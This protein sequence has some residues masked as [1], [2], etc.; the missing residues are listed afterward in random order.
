MKKNNPMKRPEQRE[1]MKNGAAARANSFNRSPS[2]EQIK[3]YKQV[4]KFYPFAILNY[5]YKNYSI[6]IAIQKLKIAIEFDGYY[7]HKG[8][9][10]IDR[11]RQEELEKDGWKFIRYRKLPNDN[12][13][14]KDL[15]GLDYEI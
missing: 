4:L 3:L 7:W 12:Q 15:L 10:E 6:D 11:K 9:E 14:N 8:R 2:K 5:Q 13:L 1:R